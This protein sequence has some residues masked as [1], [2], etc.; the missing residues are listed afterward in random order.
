MTERYEQFK[1]GDGFPDTGVTLLKIDTIVFEY[2]KNSISPSI[3]SNG[4]EVKVPVMFGSPERWAAVRKDGYFRDQNGKIQKPVIMIRRTGFSKN[5]QLMAPNRHLNYLIEKKYS[6]H[7][8]YDTFSVLNRTRKEAKTREFYSISL[9]DHIT[10][11]YEIIVWTDTVEQNNSVCEKINF[12]AEDYWGQENGY[13][14]RTEASEYNLSVETPSEQERIVK[15]S[16]SLTV[17]SYLLPNRFE[18]GKETVQKNYSYKK[19]IVKEEIV[20]SITNKSDGG[21]R[22][23]LFFYPYKNYPKKN[24]P[25]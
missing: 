18:N 15:T 24:P 17:Y 8:Q 10:I 3:I 19:V 6:E 23:D 16:F 25:R 4:T 14:F 21:G 7:N 5:E 22:D 20:D 1:R 2:L 13:K 11:T 9:P 12:S